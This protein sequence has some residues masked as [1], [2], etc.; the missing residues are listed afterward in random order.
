MEERSWNPKRK[1]VKT[2][3]GEEAQK[4]GVDRY[5]IVTHEIKM[6]H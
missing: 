2:L 5:N 4:K 3:D 1:V 6:G